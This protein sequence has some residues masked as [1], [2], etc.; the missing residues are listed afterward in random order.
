M[1]LPSINAWLL[2]KAK[3]F[4]CEHASYQL[5]DLRL[6]VENL[7]DRITLVNREKTERLTIDTGLSFRNLSSG[8]EQSAARVGYH[9]TE[10]GRQHPFPCQSLVLSQLH[11]HPSASVNIAWAHS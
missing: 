9:R 3:L 4:L 2:T 1:P 11:I 5:D 7:F 6:Q 10:A 8:K